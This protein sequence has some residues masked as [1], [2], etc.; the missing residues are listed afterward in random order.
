MGLRQAY[1][2]AACYAH[3]AWHGVRCTMR[4]CGGRSQLEPACH[5]AAA[6]EKR[7]EEEAAARKADVAQAQE[8][9]TTPG[10]CGWRV[11]Q[12]SMV[13]TAGSCSSSARGRPIFAQLYSMAGCR[14]A[15]S[16]WQCRS[17]PLAL[18]RCAG[19]KYHV[20]CSLGSG[21]YTEWQ[22]R[23]VGGTAFSCTCWC[24]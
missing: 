8:T 9:N 5:A 21:V 18:P 16:R 14:V 15:S 12:C 4:G 22:S 2:A 7:R 19:E 6:S 1:S 3:G 10:A 20:I 23:V 17:I 24:S 13:G 11:V